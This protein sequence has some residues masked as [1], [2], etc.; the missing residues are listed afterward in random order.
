MNND[1]P[2]WTGIPEGTVELAKMCFDWGNP[3]LE[4]LQVSGTVWNPH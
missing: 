4:D 3:M 1:S 2:Y